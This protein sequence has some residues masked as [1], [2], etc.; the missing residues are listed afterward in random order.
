ME[1]ETERRLKVERERDG[2]RRLEVERQTE[3]DPTI[4]EALA[5]SWFPRAGR[6]K[7]VAA[8]QDTPSF[9]NIPAHTQTF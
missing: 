2:E 3:R 1:R 9:F 4:L 8:R 7:P 6:M 5:I